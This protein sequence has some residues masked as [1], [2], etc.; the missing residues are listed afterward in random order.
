M[1]SSSTLI[2]FS[3][4]IFYYVTQ[5]RNQISCIQRA[6]ILEVSIW[7]YSTLAQVKLSKSFHFVNQA[8][9]KVIFSLFQSFDYLNI[10]KLGV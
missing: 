6:K 2:P 4:I 3:T 9:F 7:M 5:F 1:A 10:F 8:I